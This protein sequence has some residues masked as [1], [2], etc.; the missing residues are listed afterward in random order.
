MRV[1]VPALFL[2]ALSFAVAACDSGGVPSAVVDFDAS[3]GDDDDFPDAQ[4]PPS[5]CDSCPDG[6]T[7]GTANGTPVC[8]A[9]SGIPRFS[10]VYV[11]LMENTSYATLEATTNTPYLHGLGDMF[12]RSS[13][14]HGVIHPSLANYI[15]LVSG[16]THGITCDCNPDEASGVCSGLNCN[17]LI[18]T[19]GCP[20]TGTTI[21]DQ[22]EAAGL[23]WRNY[24]ET[25]GTPCNLTGAGEYA[26]RHV[27]FIYFG[28]FV[29]D[30]ARCADHVVDYAGFAADLAAPRTF[31]FISPNLVSDMH[32]P[33]PAG[34]QNYANGDAWLAAAL[35]PILARPE[36]QPGGR[37]LLVVVWDEDD[38]SGIFAPDDPIPMYVISPLAKSGGYLS[39]VKADH[40][41]LL[42]TFEDGLGLPRLGSAQAATPLQD[43][44]PAQ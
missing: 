36:M 13:D 5:E 10:H 26:P 3:I 34:A 37:G 14:Y 43:F 31:S 39:T 27:P 25:M 23:T 24:A 12:A 33:V 42:A 35:P 16:E 7:C 22:L 9:P 28:P 6:Y 21:A 19:C 11:V 44:F 17:A 29:A 20:Q 18:H 2:L 38:L 41:A 40:Y 32:D 1:V 30:S 15:A 8:R 4:L